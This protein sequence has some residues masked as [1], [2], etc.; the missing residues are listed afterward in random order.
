MTPEQE[1]YT[2]SKLTDNIQALLEKNF[3]FIWISGEISNFRMPISGHCYFT[4]KDKHAQISSVVF[5]G[6]HRKLKFNIEDGIRITG[7]GRVSVYKP[8]GT[9]QIIFEYLE[10]MGVGALQFAFEQLKAKLSDE[11]LF[12]DHH[13]K[14][15]PILPRKI[16]LIT[17]PA[18]AVLHDFVKVARRRFPN[19]PICVVPVKVQGDG[20]DDE[21]ISALERV[22]RQGDADVV[23]LARGGGSL[24]DLQAFNTE[25]LARAIY[26]SET[27][28]VSA[29]GHETDFTIADFVADL[30]APTPSAAAEWVVPVKSELMLQRERLL[31]SLVG[32]TR[33]AFEQ[34]YNQINNLTQKM[35]DPKK[36]IEMLNLRIDD[37]A[38]RLT[39]MVQKDLN[40]RREKMSWRIQSLYANSPQDTVKR[41]REEIYNISDKLRTGT[42]KQM[43]NATHQLKLISAMLNG[44]SPLAILD[45]GYS[46][47]RTINEKAIIRDQSDAK[48]GQRLEILLSKGSLEVTVQKRG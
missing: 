21:I 30:R 23:V 5:R 42:L 29:V 9:Y 48:L 7:L 3:P 34:F 24:E 39:S 16:A 1:I 22:N 37:M 2:V 31:R 38:N 36:R 8:R 44:L 43:G 6:R 32:T 10:P 15:L 12:S 41:C 45:R 11:G 27:P 35:V 19:L 14:P 47:T 33:S 4:L 20:S 46:I 26:L 28:V 40:R 18:G 25:S 17:S 13:K